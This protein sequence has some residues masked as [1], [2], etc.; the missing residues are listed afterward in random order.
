MKTSLSLLFSIF[1][2]SSFAQ[3]TLKHTVLFNVDSYQIRSEELIELKSFL[4]S[5]ENRQVNAVFIDGHTDHDASE[6]YNQTLSEN[7][8]NSVVMQLPGSWTNTTISTTGHG[9]LSPVQ[10]NASTTGKQAN[11]RVELRCIVSSFKPV[12]TDF[13]FDGWEQT[14]QSF[15]INPFTENTIKGKDGTVIYIPANSFCGVTGNEVTIRLKEYIKL[16]DI[17]LAQLTTS[18][19]NRMLETRGMVDLS[20][21][22]SSTELKLCKPITLFFPTEGSP[23]GFKLFNGEHLPNENIVN[24]HAQENSRAQGI[25]P[26][27]A[28]GGSGASNAALN[29][30]MRSLSPVVK[31]RCYGGCQNQVL[32][33]RGRELYR[34]YYRNDDVIRAL[35]KRHWIRRTVSLDR[36]YGM[37]TKLNNRSPDTIRTNILRPCFNFAMLNGAQAEFMDSMLEGGSIDPKYLDASINY[38]AAQTSQLGLINCD[39]FSNRINTGNFTFTY[40]LA[41][42][43]VSSRLIFHNIRSIMYG[44]P[45]EG[46]AHFSNIPYGEAVTL[47]VIKYFRDKIWV[48]KS[49][50][51]LGDK[52]N[53]TFEE[54]P[55]D[56]LADR[57]KSITAAI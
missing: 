52:P 11:R 27:L 5:I 28:L 53:L 21:H 16:E 22:E 18:S 34:S 30:C 9:E 3:D 32:T 36:Y 38:L 39:R 40:G 46:K 1:C 10:P 45:H 31:I 33:E 55:K 23:K 6:N 2:I 17:V 51:K 42:G 35:R 19:N 7:R 37:Y 25:N 48:G 20:A 44:H 24:W 29:N 49:I 57:I 56:K 47:L 54:V 50:F 26:N 43:Q 14:E 41:D 13:Y 12:S 4:K 8:V 15:A